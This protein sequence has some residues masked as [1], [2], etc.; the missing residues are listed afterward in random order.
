M[1]IE[2]LVNNLESRKSKVFGTTKVK[3]NLKMLVDSGEINEGTSF[4]VVENF[5]AIS[6]E[7][8]NKWKCNLGNSEKFKWVLLRKT[9]EWK[10]IQDSPNE[11]LITRT[12]RDEIRVFDQWTLIKSVIV[13]QLGT[14]NKENIPVSD[15]WVQIFLK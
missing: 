8:V 6:L 7:Y 15:R 1:N 10:K 5:Y 2:N 12:E 3:K 9:P 13:G 11:E 4:E 14:R